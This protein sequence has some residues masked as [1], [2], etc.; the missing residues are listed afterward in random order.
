M[1]AQT[2]GN[3]MTDEANVVRQA[4]AAACDRMFVKPQ[5]EP[6]G[7]IAPSAGQLQADALGMI[8]DG[9]FGA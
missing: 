5:D 7:V 1:C 4:L 2:D 3:V 9:A 6:P 8:A